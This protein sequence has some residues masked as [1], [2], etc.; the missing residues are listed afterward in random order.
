MVVDEAYID[1]ADGGSMLPDLARFPNL[2]ILRTFSKGYGRAAVRLGFAIASPEII[3]LF[4]KVKT[5]YNLSALTMHL[6]CLAL[7]DRESRE[8]NIRSAETGAR[9][10]QFRAAESVRGV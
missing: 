8:E 1:F 2:I 4:L 9:A 7:A 10:N 3:K 6:G 5:P